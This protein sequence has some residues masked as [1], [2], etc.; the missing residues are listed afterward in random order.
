MKKTM[1]MIASSQIKDFEAKGR[2]KESWFVDLAIN[3]D[4]RL[5]IVSQSVYAAKDQAIALRSVQPQE[6]GLGT[7][8]HEEP[9]VKDQVKAQ[10]DYMAG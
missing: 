7:P 10:D 3:P 2:I 9:L 1:R 8:T 6:E 4:T 5:W